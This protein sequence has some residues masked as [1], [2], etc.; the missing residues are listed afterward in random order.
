[1]RLRS[2]MVPRQLEFVG[3]LDHTASHKLARS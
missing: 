1:M 3:S 2:H